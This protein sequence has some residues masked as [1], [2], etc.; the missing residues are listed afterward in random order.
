MRRI[1]AGGGHVRFKATY[2]LIEIEQL[3]RGKSFNVGET[4]TLALRDYYEW[5]GLPSIMRH[6]TFFTQRSRLLSQSVESADRLSLF[7]P[8]LTHCIAKWLLVDYKL[9]SYPYSDLNIINI[10]TNLPQ[11]L[12]IAKSMMLYFRETLSQDMFGRIK[13]I[14]VPLHRHRQKLSS[15]MTNGIPGEVQIVNDGA[16]FLS[17]NSSNYNSKPF[18]IEDPVYFLMLDDVMKNTSHDLVKCNQDTGHWEQCFVDINQNGSRT[19]RFDG[20]M[21]YWCD[22]ALK[23]VLENYDTNFAAKGQELYIPTRLVELFTLLRECAPAHKLFAIDTPQRWDPSFLSMIQ[24]LLGYRPS[25]A[26]K[27]LGPE[28]SSLWSGH[29]E[30]TGPRFAI[31]FSQARQLYTGINESSGICEVKD[32]GDFVDQWFDPRH[33][34]VEGMTND[35]ISSQLEVIAGSLLAI[36]HSS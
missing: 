29:R 15:K 17:D 21:D 10:Y 27:I 13:Y 31:D 11:S 33:D 20:E 19:R 6:E 36:L 7:D 16:V 1:I 4:G 32:M 12:R 3:R 2:P 18:A 35:K 25:R 9:N 34:K 24:L 28:R 30:D 22:I 26:S 5:L 8:I 14:M 23:K